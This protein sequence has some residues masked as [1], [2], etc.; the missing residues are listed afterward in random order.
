M[1]GWINK[2]LSRI[3]SGRSGHGQ[4]GHNPICLETI[5]NAIGRDN[6]K[7]RAPAPAGHPRIILYIGQLGPGGAERQLCYTA[8]GLHGRGYDVTVLTT[9]RPS[10]EL[11]YYLP[12]LK[13][14]GVP[15][16]SARSAPLEKLITRKNTLP[17]I[18]FDVLQAVPANLF[19]QVA[20]LVNE[21]LTI[22]PGILHCWLDHSNIIGGLAGFIT[23][24]PGIFLGCR[25]MNPTNF[26]F[27]EPWLDPWYKTLMK[28]SRVVM[29]NNSR[30]GAEDYARW[31]GASPSTFHVIYNGLDFG[32]LR[33]PPKNEVRTFRTSIGAHD[34]PL[35][36]GI[37]RIGPEKRPFDF[38]SVID[39]VQERIGTV[40]AVI[41]GTGILENEVGKFIRSHGLEDTVKLLG[42]R[43]DIYTVIRACDLILHT[44][45]N[46]G[47]P[48]ALMEAQY[49]GV[50]VV[51]TRAGGTPEILS[52]GVSALLHPVGDIEGLAS[53][54][55]SILSDRTKAAH[56]AEAGHRLMKEKFSLDRMIDDMIQLYSGVIR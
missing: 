18:D 17:G 26:P 30:A 32:T 55:V 8:A 48:N 52:D 37:F 24:V 35:I 39:R 3:R 54:A 11:G 46:D 27:Y 51:A 12:Y 10:G 1:T 2:L 13:E 36:G 34:K 7:V 50:P 19:D 44:S 40:R 31:L 56:L 9:S 42:V 21:L 41:A 15:A 38:L 33:V 5:E 47:N 25:N 6:Q 45:E 49:L 4:N 53:S 22:E 23:G 20:A 16:H 43:S 14:H 29:L 28:S